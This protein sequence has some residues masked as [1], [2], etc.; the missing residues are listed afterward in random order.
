MQYTNREENWNLT[1]TENGIHITKV[2]PWSDRPTTGDELAAVKGLQIHDAFYSWQ[3]QGMIFLLSGSKEGHAGTIYRL[4]K[5]A[6]NG[7]GEMDI[8]SIELSYD[9]FFLVRHGKRMA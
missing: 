1:S 9:D 4:M 5:V 2:L 6:P 8:H 7:S 3:E